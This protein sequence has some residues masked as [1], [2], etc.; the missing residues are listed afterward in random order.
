MNSTIEIHDSRVAEISECDGTVIVH[1]KPAYLHKSDGRPAFDSGTTWAQEARL[2]FSEAS[3]VGDFPEWPCDVMDGEIV[4][5]GVCHSNLIPVLLE[6]ETPTELRL[7][8]DSAHTVTVASK[9]VRM[10]LI[11]EPRF[12]EEF[13]IGG[14]HGILVNKSP[15]TTQESRMLDQMHTPIKIFLTFIMALVALL[16]IGFALWFMLT[17]GLRFHRV[18]DENAERQMVSLLNGDPTVD[19][20]SFEIRNQMR[21]LIC[22][23]REVIGYLKQML[24]NHS[25]VIREGS[26]GTSYV[27][28]FT[29]NSGSTFVGYLGVFT[30]SFTI[31]IP[32]QA[33][34]ESFPT[35][36]VLLRPPVPEKVRQA[37][38]FLD[39]PW[40]KVAGTVLIMDDGKGLER[41]Y[42][43]S[44]IS[45]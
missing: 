30:N 21:K 45:R 33:A 27:G 1:F 22:T 7:V 13:P 8:C 44:L 42:D 39:E 9:R 26:G 5:D 29:F 12:V 10:E 32:S 19:L 18:E 3:V 43:A 11:D 37:F 17:G 14:Q 40:Q 16:V 36:Y 34:E 35:H 31:S 20:K 15:P 41:R 23:D 4:L 38:E 28:T 24:L 2:I 25:N 6:I